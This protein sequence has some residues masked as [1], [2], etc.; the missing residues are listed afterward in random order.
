MLCTC[1]L[2]HPYVRGKAALLCGHPLMPNASQRCVPDGG[3]M[4]APWGIHGV[5][6]WGSHVCP[7]QTSLRAKLEE[8]E[9][10]VSIQRRLAGPGQNHVQGQC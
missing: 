6:R 3:H 9:Q 5:Y 10:A 8:K 2:V 7:V 1:A 4:Y